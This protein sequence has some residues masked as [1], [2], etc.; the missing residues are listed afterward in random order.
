MRYTRN[1]EDES[2]YTKQ[3]HQPPQRNPRSED[4]PELGARNDR[5]NRNR[6][7]EATEKDSIGGSGS[8]SVKQQTISH[9]NDENVSAPVSQNQRRFGANRNENR[10][11]NSNSVR[12]NDHEYDRRGGN[13]K[14]DKNDGRN[15]RSG[16]SGSGGGRST[17]EYKSQN[18]NRNNAHGGDYEPHNNRNH[19]R[20]NSSHNET[21]PTAG[22]HHHDE[23]VESI[24]F[25][26]SKISSGNSN[27]GGRYSSNVDYPNHSRSTKDRD[28]GERQDDSQSSQ[29]QYNQSSQ[30]LAGNRQQQQ[31]QQQPQSQQQPN[32]SHQIQRQ[33]QST[34]LTTN[35]SLPISSSAISNP[36]NQ[37]Q[38]TVQQMHNQPQPQQQQQQ[39][40]AQQ[41]QPPQSGD[42]QAIM[43][44]ES[45]RPKRYSSQRQRSVIEHQS[46]PPQIPLNEIQMQMTA[47][48]PNMILQMPSGD[49]TSVTANYTHPK[50][51][52]PPA[53]N[54]TM[55][56]D[57]NT[58]KQPPPVPN[59]AA[60]QQFQ[61]N[62]YNPAAEYAQNVP[63]IQPNV[64][65]A[66]PHHPQQYGQAAPPPPFIQSATASTFIQQGQPPNPAVVQ[67]MI[68]YVPA[69]NPL[70]GAP[71][72]PPNVAN[73]QVVNQTA[74]G[75]FQQYPPF[76]AVQNYNTA[77]SQA[78]H[79]SDFS[80]IS[81]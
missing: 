10:R 49:E 29:H 60:Q 13:N 48:E 27:S 45:N 56:I 72:V 21:K 14:T 33:H 22:S 43:M 18:R 53:G 39:S 55:G 79:Q 80:K 63:Q 71:V 68:N 66:P 59:V 30:R 46:A 41:T 62:Y 5:R 4:F 40:A 67:Q 76:P 11:G 3:N 31:Q 25:T 57:Y 23:R 12:E 2:A 34:L 15:Y 16:G 7:D 17:I 73:P 52:P 8:G 44:H 36:I 78:H 77:V 47:A 51:P 64:T 32:Q 65:A 42:R 74:Q 37:Q 26:N 28:Y 58:P 20:N 50:G 69:H 54:Y 61:P 70:Q 6:S 38:S 81:F 9:P 1:W 19:N 35:H 75:Q 24:S